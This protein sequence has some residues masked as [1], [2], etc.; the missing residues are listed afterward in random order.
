[1]FV[2]QGKEED[3]A[4]AAPEAALPDAGGGGDAQGEAED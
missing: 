2:T 4:A 1:M 3:V